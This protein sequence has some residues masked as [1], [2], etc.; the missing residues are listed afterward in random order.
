MDFK[1]ANAPEYPQMELIELQCSYEQRTR[2]QNI[3][4]IDYYKQLSTIPVCIYQRKE[5]RPAA[6]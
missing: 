5:V 4:L 6:T 2:F 3:E 1:V